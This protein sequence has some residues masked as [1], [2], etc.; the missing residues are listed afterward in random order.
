MKRLA[1]DCVV[2]STQEHFLQE[3]VYL[4]VA[5]ELGYVD[6]VHHLPRDG[7][8]TGQGQKKASETASWVIL[9]VTDVVFQIYLQSVHDSKL[10]SEW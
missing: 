2:L 8:Q 5:T 6:L 4:C 9:P 1:D 7:L 3:A 10:E